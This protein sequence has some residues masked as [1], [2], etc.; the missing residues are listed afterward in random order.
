MFFAVSWPAILDTASYPCNMF[1]HCNN[2]AVAPSNA[3]LKYLVLL[4]EL[5]RWCKFKPIDPLVFLVL[6]LVTLHLFI[7]GPQHRQTRTEQG[8]IQPVHIVRP[9]LGT[10]STI[11]IIRMSV[12]Q[13]FEKK[14]LVWLLH[15]MEN[16]KYICFLLHSTS[17]LYME[18]ARKR[19]CAKRKSVYILY[20]RNRAVDSN[21]FL[22]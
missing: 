16:E 19:D 22:F 12:R 7:I 13:S 2:M 9:R 6:D 4:L 1:T 15:Y 3:L 11:S 5:S 20:I 18:K 21:H 17:R 8:L 10:S 14:F